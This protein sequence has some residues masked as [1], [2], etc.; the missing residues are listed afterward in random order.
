MFYQYTCSAVQSATAGH[1]D[2]QELALVSFVV[3]G[4][5]APAAKRAKLVSND[6][7]HSP[8]QVSWA[9][10]HSCILHLIS[11]NKTLGVHKTE[12]LK[13]KGAYVYKKKS[14][15][16]LHLIYLGL[17]YLLWFL[18]FKEKKNQPRKAHV[19]TL[20]IRYQCSGSELLP[21]HQCFL[22]NFQFVMKRWAFPLVIKPSSF[23]IKVDLVF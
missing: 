1:A 2:L 17:M 20:I 16:D 7:E 9:L 21:R 6:T 13:R 22:L 10:F 4:S 11:L 15:F 19:N 14:R 12:I 3:K 8:W 23:D 5:V 18:L